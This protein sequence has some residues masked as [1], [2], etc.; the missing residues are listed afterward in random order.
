[1]NSGEQGCSDELVEGMGSCAITLESRGAYTITATYS[2]DMY[3]S[4]SVDAASHL[5]VDFL[6]IFIPI[7]L[8]SE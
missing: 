7:V 5:V 6:R 2:G 1:M 4:P 8:R 3:F